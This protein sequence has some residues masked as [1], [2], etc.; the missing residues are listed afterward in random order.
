[1][2]IT[3]VV[4]TIKDSYENVDVKVDDNKIKIIKKEWKREVEFEF[5]T[6]NLNE[7]IDDISYFLS[8]VYIPFKGCLNKNKVEIAI[9]ISNTIFPMQF[10]GEEVSDDEK[11]EENICFDIGCV[12]N[13]F[14]KILDSRHDFRWASPDEF[15]STLQIF[16]LDKVTKRSYDE[17]NFFEDVV[18][19]VAKDIIFDLSTRYSLNLK[20]Y[21]VPETEEI[22]NDPFY[23]AADILKTQ[24]HFSLKVSYDEDLTNYYYRALQ[25][26]NSEFKYLAYYQVMECIFDEVY[27]EET[28]YDVRQI[29][30]S[31]GFSSYKNDDVMSIIKVVEQYNKNKTDREKMKVILEK[32]FRGSTHDEAYFIANKEII[33]LLTKKGE[34][35]KKEDIKDIQK[36]TNVIYD[37]RCKCTHSNR[38]FPFRKTFD[39]TDNEL[40]IY[41]SIIKK[42]AERVISNY[43]VMLLK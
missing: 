26:D 10:S 1:M 34:I 12:T 8:Y 16:N 15:L 18:L 32:Y 41:I 35:Q 33:E 27:L 21:E 19:K 20:L 37:F 17:E 9:T 24:E 2:D 38:K 28:I 22:D 31:S 23:E 39:N 13:D 30:N 43:N 14:I 7:T 42:I 11:K 40:G 4:K 6:D 5:N 29:I 25:M 36:L 3:E